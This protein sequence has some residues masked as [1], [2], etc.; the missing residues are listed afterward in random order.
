MGNAAQIAAY[1][2]RH[3]AYPSQIVIGVD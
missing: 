3:P 2:P 1:S